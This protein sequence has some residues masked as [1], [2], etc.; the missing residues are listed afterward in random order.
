MSLAKKKYSFHRK[1]INNYQ[2][3][4]IIPTFYPNENE[5][6]NKVGDNP[7]LNIKIPNDN[8]ICQINT[9]N[10]INKESVSSI[11]MPVPSIKENINNEKKESEILSS[12]PDL[13]YLINQNEA[14]NIDFI[15]TLL[16]LKGISIESTKSYQSSKNIDIM[17]KYEEENILAPKSSKTNDIFLLNNKVKYKSIPS[18]CSTS[19]SKI[20]SINYN[21]QNIQNEEDETSKK[22]DS[23]SINE[24]NN[25]HDNI[26]KEKNN[27]IKLSKIDQDSLLKELTTLDNI[28]SKKEINNISHGN[29]DSL[30]SEC[31]TSNTIKNNIKMDFSSDFIN[32]KENY[33]NIKYSEN[34]NNKDIINILDNKNTELHKKLKNRAIIPN[35]GEKINKTFCKQNTNSKNLQNINNLKNLSKNNRKSN[36]SSDKKII[37][38]KSVKRIPYNKKKIN[39]NIETNN[40]NNKIS[41]KERNSKSKNTHIISTNKKSHKRENS[42]KE[43]IKSEIK[44]NRSVNIPNKIIKTKEFINNNM[45]LIKKSQ[46]NGSNYSNKKSNNMQ[47]LS[48]N[49]YTEMKH[50]SKI[51]EKNN[52]KIE[53]KLIFETKEKIEQNSIKKEEIKNNYEQIREIDL[54]DIRKYPETIKIKAI[55]KNQINN[56]INKNIKKENFF[57]DI[58][59][60]SERKTT[61]LFKLRDNIK[62]KTEIS[63][64]RSNNI[65]DLNYRNKSN[66][67]NNKFKNI[68]SLNSYVKI[69][70]NKNYI[71]PTL[72]HRNIR[73]TANINRTK[74]NEDIL[75]KRH[76]ISDN[77]LSFNNFKNNLND[78]N[79]NS[80]NKNNYIIK[81]E[82]IKSNNINDGKKIDI[83]K[84]EKNDGDT[85][86]KTIDINDSEFN[87]NRIKEI[88]TIKKKEK[89]ESKFAEIFL[90]D[91]EEELLKDNKDKSIENNRYNN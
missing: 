42:K 15:N 58:P 49:Y 70:K 30:S 6:D 53:K 9:K 25:N 3:A 19:T 57:I 56:I 34:F 22:L 2:N 75:N 54:K 60:Y 74:D 47:R 37:K 18:N 78:D 65:S 10:E 89:I 45:T 14:E 81:T 27:N 24:I 88:K 51:C 72:K 82:K 40:N 32:P 1:K 38:K 4:T 91:K 46:D 44:N 68:S 61:K 71:S 7:N 13:Q 23:I 43:I 21:Y 48:Q 39:T 62:I 5:N 50:E 87:D 16:K 66:K 77:E 52:N 69:A 33:I 41:S 67:H 20:N 36:I 59:F 73:Y 80:I 76:E 79:D 55:N 11:P 26:K 17:K 85:L 35:K 29:K 8:L 83:L 90:F 63:P 86:N 64:N 28:E 31:N 84:A 12:D